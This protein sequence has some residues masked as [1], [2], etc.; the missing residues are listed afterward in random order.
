MKKLLIKTERQRVETCRA[1]MAEPLPMFIQYGKPRN[2][3]SQAQNALTH[4]WYDQV[5]YTLAEAPAEGV[6]REAKLLFGVPIL[7]AEDDEFRRLYTKTFDRLSY[8]EQLEAMRYLPVTSLM[9]MAQISRYMTDMQNHYAQEG[10]I[11]EGE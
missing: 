10:V 6:K 1:M 8:E 9:N 7:C 4:V 11:L 3:R 2:L 5:S